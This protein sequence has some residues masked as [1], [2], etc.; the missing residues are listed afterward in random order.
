V[1]NGEIIDRLG[2]QSKIFALAPRDL[3]I[4]APLAFDGPAAPLPVSKTLAKANTD[5][6]RLRRLLTSL[7]WSRPRVPQALLRLGPP[8]NG[9]LVHC[10]K[11]IRAALAG[12]G[13]WKIA[14]LVA[15]EAFL[16]SPNGP[17]RSASPP[18]HINRCRP[19][20]HL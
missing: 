7:S 18:R 12:W 16:G 13:A 15:D 5:G 17:N 2:K 10:W 1:P 8:K 20:D 3:Y 14:S 6:Y 4:V 19:P 11:I 9:S